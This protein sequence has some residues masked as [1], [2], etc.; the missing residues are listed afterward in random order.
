VRWKDCEIGSHLPL[1]IRYF[2]CTVCQGVI[3]LNS[4][5][6]GNSAVVLHMNE[7]KTTQPDHRI[8]D[9]AALAC[10]LVGALGLAY[11]LITYWGWDLSAL[12]R[13]LVV[14]GAVWLAVSV[15]PMALRRLSRPFHLTG[16]LFVVAAAVL[17]MPVWFLTFGTTSGRVILLWWQWIC[18]ACAA[19][20]YVLSRYGMVVVRS[21]LFPV[22]FFAFS[23]PL[24]T[25][26]EGPLQ[27]ALQRVTT[28]AAFRLLQVG[29]ATIE[30]PGGGFILRLPSGD[31]GVE[32]ACSGVRS[33][34]ALTALAAYVAFRRGF[35]PIRGVALVMATVP[36]VAVVNVVRVVLSGIIQEVAGRAFIQGNWHDTLGI[37]LVLLGL[38]VICL[39]ANLLGRF[40]GPAEAGTT[41]GE[42]GNEQ[43]RPSL[44][45]I[46]TSR[47]WVV[48]V[49][50]VAIVTGAILSAFGG[51]RASTSSGTDLPA[52]ELS[53]ISLKLAD[54]QGEVL[55]VP[56]H[57]ITTLQSDIALHREYRNGTG[58][59]A[60]VWMLYWTAAG[61][62]R[63]Y[64]HPDVCLPS[65]GLNLVERGHETIR[66]TD[67]GEISVTT[68]TL[69]GERRKLYA[70]YWTQEGRR[71]WGEA[72]EIAASRSLGIRGLI[73]RLQET[74]TPVSGGRLVVLV[75]TEDTSAFGRAEALQLGR[76]LADAV[77]KL[78]PSACPPEPV[79][80]ADLKVIKRPPTN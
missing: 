52:P 39:V 35:G 51:W 29:G 18:L 49:A 34:T 13:Y 47:R 73:T 62:V 8:A 76:L 63:G 23:L 65:V 38:G 68:R 75:G 20:G 24:P 1:P 59:R 30:R 57:I 9:R 41:T 26:V 56:E 44:S 37:L 3:L 66:P 69:M 22:I 74:S 55:P 46:Q 31:L 60:T 64:H 2:N 19:S 21:G 79:Q 61:R 16:L 40:S 32:E 11:S 50:S 54:W 42:S 58:Q 67:G 45:Q 43:H 33:L 78:C 48:S 70:L 4:S 6:P 7:P 5:S 53:T 77:Y 14:A 28:T 25:A 12:D 15:W 72:D 27:N 17:Y 71:V 10:L 36:I 80:S